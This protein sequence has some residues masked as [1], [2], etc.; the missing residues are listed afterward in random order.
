M[1]SPRRKPYIAV[2]ADFLFL[3]VG[4]LKAKAHTDAGH[5]DGEGR[6]EAQDTGDWRAAE[7]IEKALT[8]VPCK[9]CGGKGFPASV[10][11]PD[12]C[13]FCDGTEGGNP[14]K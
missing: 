13:T 11:G 7:N 3:A 9:T 8:S 12:R 5:S 10:L 2:R 4:A 14:P 6:Y 1:N